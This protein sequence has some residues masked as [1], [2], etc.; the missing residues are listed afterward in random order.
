MMQ[1]ALG[2][3]GAAIVATLIAVSALTSANATILTGARTGY[4]FGRNARLFAA[5]GKWDAKRNAPVRAL[6]VQAAIALALILVG[7]LTRSGFST[8]VE[9][10]APVFWLFFVLTG[11]SL[12]VLRSKFPEKRRPFSVPLY[13]L[14]PLVFCATSTYLLYASVRHTGIGAL[15]G[16]SVLAVGALLL[17]S[18]HSS[19][20]VTSP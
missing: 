11:V 6:W 4:A 9:Y 20:T 8:M 18:K 13:P 10:T 12:F 16:L 2:P 1:I 14:V 7:A 17:L 5:L 19:E 3:I 15:V